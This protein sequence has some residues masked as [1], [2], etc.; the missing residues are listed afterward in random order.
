MKV[1]VQRWSHRIESGIAFLITR[2]AY[3]NFCRLRD[4]EPQGSDVLGNDGYVTEFLEA[5]KAD[6]GNLTTRRASEP[7]ESKMWTR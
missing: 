7:L 6:A 3:R 4:L 5:L 1:S 2:D